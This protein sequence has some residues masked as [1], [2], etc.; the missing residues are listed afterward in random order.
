MVV[1]EIGIFTI[2]ACIIGI[3][4]FLFSLNIMWKILGLFPQEA[5]IKKYWY[6]AIGLVI[7]FGFGYIVAI[8]SVITEFSIF[9]RIMVPIVYL[10]GSIFVVIM[11]LVSFRTYKMIMD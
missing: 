4:N 10:F 2:L 5:K 8:L 3:L 1:D 6:S 11:V 7:L 9:N